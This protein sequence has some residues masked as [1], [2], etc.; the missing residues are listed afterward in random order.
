VTWDGTD[1]AGRR[2]PAG[3][4]IYSLETRTRLIGRRLTL[5]R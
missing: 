5:V 3:V 2:V 4:F 1:S